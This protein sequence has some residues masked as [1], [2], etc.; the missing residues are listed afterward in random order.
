MSVFT[1]KQF[2][3]STGPR[4]VNLSVSIRQDQKD[5]LEFQQNKNK[6][7]VTNHRRTRPRE[8][9]PDWRPCINPTQKSTG[10]NGFM[11]I[12]ATDCAGK[13]KNTKWLRC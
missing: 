3:K 7:N 12:F 8:I 9:Y 13:R 5:F 11:I 2:K 10:E 6:L 1:L 4:L